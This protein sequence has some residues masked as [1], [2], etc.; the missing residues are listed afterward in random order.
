LVAVIG[1]VVLVARFKVHA[2]L[3]LILA[4]LFVGLVSQMDL[5]VIAKTFQEGVGN[6]LGSIAVVVGLGTMLGKMLAESGGAGVV[7]NTFIR[8]TGRGRLP[9]TLLLVAFIVGT[10]V[11]FGV[12]LVLLVPIL[13]TLVRETKAPLLLLGIPVV[14]GLS[15]S[16][17]LVP[18]H[19]G[20]MVAIETL[21]ADV[22]KTILYAL[23]VGLPAAVLA[24]PLFGKFIAARVPV[25][26]GGLGERLAVPPNRARR[27]GFAITLFTIL[28][29]VLLMLVATLG[30]VALPKDHPLRPWSL[31]IGSPLVALL[32]ATLFSFYSFGA[33]CGVGREQILKFMEDCVG[34]AANIMLVVGAGGGFSKVLEGCGAANAI[35]G[36]A[37]GLPVS[38]LLLGWL[39][40]AAIRVVVGSATVAITLSSGLMAPI[41]ASQAGVS[42][43][44]LVLALGS[45]SLVLSH[46]NDGGF[47]FVKEYFN[48]TVPQTLKSWTVMETILA[49]VTLLLVLGLDALR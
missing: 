22:G 5:A 16:H 38:P 28:L 11:F 30:Q 24:G 13:F 4:S 31:L 35:A 10:P 1:L 34:P 25:E 36:M 23:V 26:T 7:A 32:A 33:G 45:G 3:A 39:I 47:W 18:P 46:L 9:W 2:F 49:V 37:K 8:W 17:G 27:P 42:P 21:H 44:L 43:E 6:T 41:V 29:P 15:V 19:P 48:L 12:G 20:P 40:A 14:A